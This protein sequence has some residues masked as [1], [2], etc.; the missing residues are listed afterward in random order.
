ML[1]RGRRWQ[2]WGRVESADPVH[3]ARPTS[4]DEAIDVVGRARELGLP[5]KAIGAG[6]SFTAI[7]VAPGI[8]VD[9]SA[10]DGVLDVDAEL[11]RVTLGA[12]TNLYQVP[13]L[14]A[15]HGLAMENLGDIDRQT[16]AG[17]TSTGTH[18][19]GGRF[20]GLAA[21]LVGATLVTADGGIL[22]VSGT[23]NAE[24]LPAV[25]LGL[26]ALGILVDVTVQCVPAFALHALEQPEPMDR[27]LDDFEDRV[28]SAD[29]FEFYWFPHTETVL[30]KTNTRLPADAPLHPLGRARRW[31][32]DSLMANGLFA[33]TCGTGRTIPAAIPGINRLA[34]RLTG[35]R[36]FTDVSTSVFTTQRSVRFRE[37]EYAIPRHLVPDAVRAIRAL[38][39]S[40][41][42]RISFPIEV[43]AAAADDLWLSTANGRD[44]GYIAVHRYWRENH[45]EYFH[46][47]EDILRGFGGRPHWGKIHFQDAES[48]SSLY[49]GFADFRAVR[50]RLDPDRVFANPYLERVLG[51]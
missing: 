39:D 35:D 12:G 11:R 7:A 6:H 42:W 32:D 26:G 5:V 1:A 44:T 45:L 51:A 34:S 41:G 13:A 48:L 10:L 43:R 22:R 31:V 27:V 18:G 23:E 50:N 16:I 40:R 29:H 25:R 3:V 36:E 24:L 47:V 46:A 15:P 14:L 19:T 8:Q 28:D 37:M 9:V 17:A 30:T 49:P 38:I 20:R 2:N 33:L 21:Q 4:V